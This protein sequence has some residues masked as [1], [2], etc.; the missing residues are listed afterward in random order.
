[1]RHDHLGNTLSHTVADDTAVCNPRVS[2][3]PALKMGSFRRNYV[4]GDSK[5]SLRPPVPY[6]KSR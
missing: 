6:S 2:G 4:Y 5:L 1:M 3:N